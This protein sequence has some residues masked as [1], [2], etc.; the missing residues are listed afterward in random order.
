LAASITAF[1]SLTIHVVES[2]DKIRT[3]VENV[4]DAPTELRRIMETLGRLGL[5]L[6]KVRKTLE[7]Q[8]EQK[9]PL[10]LRPSSL[11]GAVL[12][13]IDR[14]LQ[15]LRAVLEKHKALFQDPG[16]RTITWSKTS[17]AFSSKAIA[18]IEERMHQD[19]TLLGTA[20]MANSTSIQYVHP[21]R[22]I[23]DPAFPRHRL[24]VNDAVY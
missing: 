22:L 3:F 17:L 23:P 19:V 9:A 5:L 6:Q 2:V 12:K 15:P 7:R 10:F 21:V 18:G 13:D 11:L 14:H 20:L 4:K 16:R 24:P 1:L 8:C